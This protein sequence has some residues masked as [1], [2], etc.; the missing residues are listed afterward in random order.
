MPLFKQ[1]VLTNDLRVKYALLGD[2]M[3]LAEDVY[4]EW[5]DHGHFNYIEPNDRCGE[6]RDVLALPALINAHTHVGDSFAKD[7]GINLSLEAVVA[8][9]DGLKH[10]LLRETPKDR[11]QASIR[12]SLNLMLAG[13]TSG[14]ADFREGGT[15]GVALLEEVLDPMLPK[16]YILARW[17]HRIEELVPLSGKIAGIGIVS[18][19]DYSIEAIEKACQFCKSR[20]LLIAMHVSETP[21]MRQ[22]SIQTRGMS[23]IDFALQLGYPAILVHVTCATGDEI[24]KFFDTNAKIVICPR[25][26]S[27][28]GGMA[29]PVA[30][31]ADEQVN[32]ALGTDNVMVNTPDLWQ[33]LQF[34]IKI[35]RLQAPGNRI[36]PSFWFRSVTIN[37]AMVLGVDRL[38]GSILVGKDAD[39]CLVNLRIWN[40]NPTPDVETNVLLRGGPAD[41]DSVYYRGELAWKR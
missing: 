27:M 4:L 21:A 20:N 9:P 40:L 6:V 7:L 8:P 36:K 22:K 33:E 10:R 15:P 24:K 19:N 28:L 2:E 30:R 34:A 29:P 39:L 13:G 5:D 26:N 12:D 38:R 16:C 37:P 14:F 31:L 25:S 1:R 18:S 11:I 41:I 32:F 3:E 35:F 23:D 17:Q